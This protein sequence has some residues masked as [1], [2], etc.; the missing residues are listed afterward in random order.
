MELEN[1]NGGLKPK[2]SG[3]RVDVHNCSYANCNFLLLRNTKKIN[4]KNSERNFKTCFPKRLTGESINV[5]E[6]YYNV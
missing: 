1:K 5:F 2:G 3:T 4:N 6:L